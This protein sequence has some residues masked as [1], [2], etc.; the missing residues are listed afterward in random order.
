MLVLATLL[1]WPS[2]SDA[3][4]PGIAVIVNKDNARRALN[5][6]E[7]RAIFQTKKTNW[8]GGSH[9]LPLNLPSDSDARARF[10][11]VVLGMSRDE[12]A[13]YWIDRKIRG[14]ERP[15][16]RIPS[17]KLVLAV[18]EKK[19]EAIG[20]VHEDQVH[21]GVRIV[22]RIKGNQVTSP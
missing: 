5:R 12:V 19:L 8:D 11:E 6:D 21:S 20:Y 13:R 15:P 7:L 16:K 18:V 10:D 2:G 3:A 17:P 1:G 14:G 22:A 9:I 4:A